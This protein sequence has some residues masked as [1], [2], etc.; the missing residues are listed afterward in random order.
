MSNR[1]TVEGRTHYHGCWRHHADCADML[2]ERIARVT[3][4]AEIELGQHG[5]DERTSDVI[6][7]L[8]ALRWYVGGD[9]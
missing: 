4:E 5:V 6:S 3:H 7:E 9:S 2:A 8:R 1:A